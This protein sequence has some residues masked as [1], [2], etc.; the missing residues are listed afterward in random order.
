[1]QILMEMIEN[2]GFKPSPVLFPQCPQNTGMLS[3]KLLAT[4]CGG[5]IQNVEPGI[6]DLA[7]LY[8]IPHLLPISGFKQLIVDSAV[9]SVKPG[10]TYIPRFDQT[11][12][13]RQG[14]QLMPSCTA[15][16]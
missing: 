6:V 12:L 1:M 7:V 13:P 5:R 14:I 9:N 2:T 3:A 16:I 11:A 15:S 8:H 4:D 10:G